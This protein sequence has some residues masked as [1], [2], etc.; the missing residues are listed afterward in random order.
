M[1][2]RFHARVRDERKFAGAEELRKQIGRD[3][4]LAKEYFAGSKAVEEV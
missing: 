3:I 4:A 2:V 1:E